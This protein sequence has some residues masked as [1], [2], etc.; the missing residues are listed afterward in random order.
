MNTPNVRLLQAR[1]GTRH[2]EQAAQGTPRTGERIQ[3]AKDILKYDVGKVDGG[4]EKGDCGG[5]GWLTSSI[6]HTVYMPAREGL[7]SGSVDGSSWSAVCKVSGDP[8]G[9]SGPQECYIGKLRAQ[10][11]HRRARRDGTLN[12]EEV[13]GRVRDWRSVCPIELTSAVRRNR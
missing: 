5:A 9:A 1:W 12:V 11:G 8:T 2:T 6:T 7:D 4:S 10:L 13:Y 3:C